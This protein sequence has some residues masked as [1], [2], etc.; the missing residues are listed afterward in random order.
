MKKVLGCLIAI[1]TVCIASITVQAAKPK[2]TVS[3][4]TAEQ[5]QMVYLTVKLSDCAKAD[6]LGISFKYDSSVLKKIASDCS[7]KEKGVLQDF[8]VA[9]DNGVWATNKVKDLNG[10]ICTLAFRVKADAPAGDTDVICKLVVKKG[11][12]EI[13]TYKA[14]GTVTVKGD[15][16]DND[17]QEEDDEHENPE[18]I[19][20]GSPDNENN[21]SSLNSSENFNKEETGKPVVSGKV[22]TNKKP[23]VSKDK[24]HQNMS[25]DSEEQQETTGEI[26]EEVTEHQHTD[27]CDH[28]ESEAEEI[29]RD[30][31]G[32]IIWFACA[33]I[34]SAGIIVF[35]IKRMNREKK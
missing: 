27:A 5:S 24:E 2:I 25:I 9:K 22:E 7:W 31:I 13:G 16:L 26:K 33:V 28:A 17:K 34:A 8:D 35:I 6:T 18:V 15:V 1:I 20:P 3:N 11:E 19:K 23:E 32:D 14:E 12:K 21:S 10:K 4:T 29:E 30:K